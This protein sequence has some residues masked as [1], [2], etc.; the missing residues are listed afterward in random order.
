LGNQKLHFD[1]QRERFVGN[2]AA[3]AYLTAA[4]RGKYRIPDAL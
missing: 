3:D 4:A 2:P 1:G